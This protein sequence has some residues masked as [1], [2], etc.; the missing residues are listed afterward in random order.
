MQPMR[1]ARFLRG[2]E[3]ILNLGRS[4]ICF[5][6]H[7]YGVLVT[8]CENL[9]TKTRDGLAGQPVLGQPAGNSVYRLVFIRTLSNLMR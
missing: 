9:L 4:W 6:R 2:V 7:S 1:A 3:Q 5:V 8:A